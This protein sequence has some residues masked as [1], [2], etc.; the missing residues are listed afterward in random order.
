MSQRQQLERIMEIDAQ[1]R[2]GLYPNA[3]RIAAKLEVSPRVIFQDKAFM[4]NRL[5]APITFDRLRGGW[6][7]TDPTW[8]LPSMFVTEGELLAFFLS[9]EVAQRYL[10]ASFEAPLRSAVSR[11]AAS[12]GER[13]Q[14]SLEELRQH[15]TFA[16]PAA[17]G[18]DARLLVDLHRAIQDQLQVRMRYYTASRDE[19]TERTVDPHHL[20]NLRGDWYLFAFDQPRQEMRSFH[21]GRVDWWQVLA[22]RFERVPGFSAQE[23]MSSAFQAERGGP[24]QQVAIRFDAYQARWIRERRWHETQQDLE[25]LPGGG[26]ILR[27]RSAGLDEIQRWAMQFGSHAEVLAPPELRQAILAEIRLMN[28]A[29]WVG[30]ED[31]LNEEGG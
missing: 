30:D 21:L 1:I 28:Q 9:V 8:T 16:A 27:F 26:V 17:P 31:A 12:L 13:A 3:A 29:Y 7:Y 10:G 2:A 15:Y 5:G 6:C 14:V 18:V 19:W 25:E 22:S 20:Y 11:L 23:W 4:L 24:P